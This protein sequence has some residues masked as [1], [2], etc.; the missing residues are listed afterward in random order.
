MKRKRIATQ[1]AV[2]ALFSALSLVM[3][4]IENQFP[5]LF[6]PGARMGLANIFS[7]AALVLFDLPAA[8]AVMTVRTVLGAIFSGNISALMYSFTGGAASLLLSAALLKFAYPKIS[9]LSVSVVA[10]VCHNVVQNLVFSL[11]SGTPLTLSY[12]PYLIILGVISGGVV[13]G[14]V[15][16]LFKKTPLSVFERLLNE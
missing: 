8:F 16:L 12:M 3:F 7:L 2:V 10:A 15:L 6:V 9:I 4:I 5:P 13:G 1:L 11:T 14:V